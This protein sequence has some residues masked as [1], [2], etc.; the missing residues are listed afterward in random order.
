MTKTKVWAA[1]ILRW[2]PN[3]FK[4]AILGWPSQKGYK[5]T[6]FCLWPLKWSVTQ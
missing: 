3:T 6:S 4:A 5:Q 2:N 1:I